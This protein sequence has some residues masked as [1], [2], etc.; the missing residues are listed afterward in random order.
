MRKMK[1]VKYVLLYAQAGGSSRDYVTLGCSGGTTDHTVEFRRVRETRQLW[2]SA[3]GTRQFWVSARGMR[4]LWASVAGIFHMPVQTASH[5]T[6][7]QKAPHIYLHLAQ[8]LVLDLVLTPRLYKEASRT[9]CVSLEL[10]TRCFHLN[11]PR[12]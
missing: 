11:R 8:A 2:A 12:V 5:D 6:R 10:A 4:Q 9:K 7:R 1:C 3:R